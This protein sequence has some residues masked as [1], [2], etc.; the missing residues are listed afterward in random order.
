M[1]YSIILLSLLMHG[2]KH[3]WDDADND[4]TGNAKNDG[5]QWVWYVRFGS[6]GR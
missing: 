3:G 4:P 5:D 6:R 1:G 2:W